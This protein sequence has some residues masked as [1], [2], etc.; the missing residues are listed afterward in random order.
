MWHGLT[1]G[2]SRLVGVLTLN[3]ETGDLG[4][5]IAEEAR[6]I[7]REAHRELLAQLERRAQQVWV[8]VTLAT[9]LPGTLLLAVPFLQAMQVFT[10]P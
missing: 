8:P 2:V 10:D 9:L 4:R 5:L 3:R 6:T 1:G 7:R